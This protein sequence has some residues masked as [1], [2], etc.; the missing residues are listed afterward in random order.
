MS[1]W[2]VCEIVPDRFFE[3]NSQHRKVVAE[4]PLETGKDSACV[5][6]N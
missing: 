4:N 5:H 3:K 2:R 1:W 6:I